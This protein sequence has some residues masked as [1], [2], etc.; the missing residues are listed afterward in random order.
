[1][2]LGAPSPFAQFG[3]LIIP[4][5]CDIHARFRKY[6]DCRQLSDKTELSGGRR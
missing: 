4:I 1:M 6:E 5:D 3:L 2:R